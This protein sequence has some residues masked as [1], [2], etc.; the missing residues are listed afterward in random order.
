MASSLF[1]P[2]AFRIPWGFLLSLKLVEELGGLRGTKEGGEG[3]AARP[4]PPVFT[5]VI[6]SS[7]TAAMGFSFYFFISCFSPASDLSQP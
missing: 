7:R 6:V 1:S 3:R 5:W 4:N 2:A